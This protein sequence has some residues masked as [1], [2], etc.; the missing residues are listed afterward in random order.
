MRCLLPVFSLVTFTLLSGCGQPNSPSTN[1]AEPEYTTDLQIVNGIV[2][3]KGSRPYMAFVLNMDMRVKCGGSIISDEWIL[4]AAH[5]INHNSDVSKITITVGAYNLA[6]AAEGEKIT[7]VKAISHPN[8]NNQALNG[9]DIGLI[10]L[11]RKIKHP[12]ASAIQLPSDPIEAILDV[13]DNMATVSGWGK[14]SGNGSTTN[15]LREVSFPITPSGSKCGNLSMPANAICGQKYQGKDTCNGD[16]GGPLVAKHKGQWYQLGVV[17][18]GP[19]KCTG[20][21]VY[22][23][24]NGYLDWIKQVSGVI[25]DD[26]TNNDQVYNG[27]VNLN[28]SS[29]QP[30]SKGFNHTGGL[31]KA[32]LHSNATGDFDLYL[33]KKEGVRWIDVGSSANTG[34]SENI[35]YNGAEGLYRWE[36]YAYE[37]QGDYQIK[38]SK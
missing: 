35:E 23:R 6:N 8:W 22:S 24:V 9:Y 3:P 18:Y 14:T 7:A 10:K 34:H 33:Q 32:T 4:T 38:I 1:P 11:S 21:G 25:P 26:D 13:K 12:D 37:G 29:F 15:Q 28:S 20:N 31:V 19:P 5:C 16:S 17:S 36:V 2:S 30:N 27:T